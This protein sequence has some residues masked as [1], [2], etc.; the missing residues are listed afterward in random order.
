MT[1]ERMLEAVF[2]KQS[3]A[4]Q[5]ILRRTCIVDFGVITEVLG[6]NVVKVGIAVADSVEDVQI[7]VCTLIS[8]CSATM[9]LNIEPSVGDKVLILFPR[10]FSSSMFKVTESDPAPII[11]S[12]CQSYSR[13]GGLA[14]LMNQ[15]NY[16]KHRKNFQLSAD[17][18][19]SIRLPYDDND[20]A[21]VITAQTDGEGKMS[22]DISK[23]DGDASLVAV[24]I[25]Q[26][27]NANLN[28]NNGKA[29]VKIDSNGNI[30]V[31]SQGK[32]TIKNGSTD[33]HTVISDLNTILKGLKTTGSETAQTIS[34]DTVTLLS[35]WESSEL[36]ALLNAP[37]VTS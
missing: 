36:E 17:G 1:Q 11:D 22:L 20:S 5:Q 31:N 24:D 2:K 14:I 28:I 7:I 27:G 4:V 35:N 33:L 13:L 3:D 19:L 37:S 9:T 21:N 12:A 34:P 16:D 10:H 32:Y 18:V 6:E 25:D 15:F 29:T 8:P 30:E 23:N 26:D